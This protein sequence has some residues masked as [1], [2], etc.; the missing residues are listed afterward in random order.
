VSFRFGLVI[1]MM[2]CLS[3]IF[4]GNFFASPPTRVISF[5]N[6]FRAIVF[7]ASLF[8]FLFNSFEIILASFL[9]CF[10]LFAITIG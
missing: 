8:A 6:L 7:F 3:L 9:F 1:S 4:S 5:W 10:N 2:S